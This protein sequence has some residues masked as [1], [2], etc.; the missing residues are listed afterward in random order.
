[1][2]EIDEIDM[3][4]TNVIIFNLADD[5]SY[6]PK[7]LSA[8]DQQS[9][10]DIISS[11]QLKVSIELVY[12]YR[13]GKPVALSTAHRPVKLHFASQ[14]HAQ[15]FTLAFWVAKKHSLHPPTHSI[16]HNL[17]GQDPS[18][19]SAL[20]G[21]P[22][23]PSIEACRRATELQILYR[24]QTPKQAKKK[25]QGKSNRSSL[26]LTSLYIKKIFT[27]HVIN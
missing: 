23:A 9:I 3:R 19:A 15:A 4:K 18:P 10:D 21:L 20:P 8:R 5:Q 7:N 14:E 27:V 24:G 25:P 22:Q 26:L 16:T 12:F 1:M 2:R 6:D 11:L 17:R 13:I